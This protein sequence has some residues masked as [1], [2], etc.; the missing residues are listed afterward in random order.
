MLLH[1]ADE[2]EAADPPDPH[3][4]RQCQHDARRGDA[5]DRDHDQRGTSGA[6]DVDDARGDRR[7]RHERG[8]VD[9]AEQEQREGNRAEAR[10]RTAAAPH[11]RDPQQLVEAAG[12]RD[13]A[14]RGRTARS[15]EGHHRRP[16]L[17]AEEPLP[18]PRL[19]AVGGEEDEAGEHHEPDVRVMDRPAVDQEVPDDEPS[20]GEREGDGEDVEKGL[21]PHKGTN[22]QPR[23]LPVDPV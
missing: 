17:A 16:A 5:C 13:P 10:A 7:E 15:G 23:G 8:A 19:E 21:Q 6:R 1:P 12:Q 4:P 3:E 20:D 14:D 22:R 18:A 9:Q 2:A 11:D